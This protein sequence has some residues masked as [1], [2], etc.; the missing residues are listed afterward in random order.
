MMKIVLKCSSSLVT[1]QSNV[2]ASGCYCCCCWL[3]DWSRTQHGCSTLIVAW[4]SARGGAEPASGSSA[5]SSPI[6]GSDGWSPRNPDCRRPSGTERALVIRAVHGTHLREMAL[7]TAPLLRQVQFWRCNTEGGHGSWWRRVSVCHPQAPTSVASRAPPWCWPSGPPHRSQRTVEF[8][9]PSRRGRIRSSTCRSD[10]QS[11][12]PASLPVLGQIEVGCRCSMVPRSGRNWNQSRSPWF[13]GCGLLWGGCSRA[14][15]LHGW[16]SSD[17]E[18]SDTRGQL[19]PTSSQTARWV[20]SN[21]PVQWVH[22][23]WW[24]AARMICRHVRGSQ[25][26]HTFGQ[27]SSD[28][29]GPENSASPRSVSRSLPSWWIDFRCGRFLEPLLIWSCDRKH[30]RPAQSLLLRGRRVPRTGRRCDPGGQVW[31]DRPWSRNLPSLRSFQ[32]ASL[33]PALWN[34]FPSILQSRSVQTPTVCEHSVEVQLPPERTLPFPTWGVHLP[35]L[36]ERRK[37]EVHLL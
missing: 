24:T 32:I 27:C 22:R 17:A 29:L 18:L 15:D 8:H 2:S 34:I 25:N 12:R 9:S 20:R 23:G 4:V 37:P 21:L 5:R 7:P 6:P 33:H 35:D 28:P 19:V 36:D 14:W 13:Y 26:V 10:I 16:S 1:R 30:W 11:C 3:V 31:N